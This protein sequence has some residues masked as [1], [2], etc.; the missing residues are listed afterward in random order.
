VSGLGLC[1][2]R[3]DLTA[4]EFLAIHQVAGALRGKP[5]SLES[6]ALGF[7]VAAAPLDFDERG[8][9]IEP[10]LIQV[11]LRDCFLV[12]EFLDSV[13]ILL[14][15][16]DAT[17]GAAQPLLRGL[18]GLLRAFDRPFGFGQRDHF[19][20]V[21]VEHRKGGLK[22]VDHR[23]SLENAGLEG[24]QIVMSQDLTL[25]DTVAGFQLNAA[26]ATGNLRGNQPGVL[27]PRPSLLA[28]RLLNR[29][30]IGMQRLNGGAAARRASQIDA[31][32]G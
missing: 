5:Q 23:A 11:R 9:M 13:Q 4:F 21:V 14:G 20:R 19:D 10:R 30:A 26:H 12:G 32:C 29:P 8:V 31:R 3:H 16:L 18:D 25:G 1:D 2:L 28:E 22:P 15:K 24:H 17:L 7:Q 6:R 27:K